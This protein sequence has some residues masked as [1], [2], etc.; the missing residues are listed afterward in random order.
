MTDICK[1]IKAVDEV[2][3]ELLFVISHVLELGGGMMKLVI[4]W[5]KVDKRASLNSRVVNL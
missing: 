3:P 5:V 2:N 4:D 1:I